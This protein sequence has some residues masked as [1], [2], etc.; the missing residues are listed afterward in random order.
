VTAEL[1]LFKRNYFLNF[2]A[3]LTLKFKLNSL[4]LTVMQININS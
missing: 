2:H 3:L 4:T 1:Q